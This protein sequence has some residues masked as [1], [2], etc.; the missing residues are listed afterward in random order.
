MVP[1]LHHYNIVSLGVRPR[2]LDRS[3]NRLAARVPEEKAVQAR[4]RH[5]GQQTLHQLDIGLRERNGALHVNDGLRL[6]DNGGSD[7][8]VGVSE[9]GDADT[10]RKVE[11][12]LIVAGQDAQSAAFFK[13]V[14]TQA[15]DTFGDVLV[16][17]GAQVGRGG[18]HGH[19][20]LGRRQGLGDGVQVDGRHFD[21][22]NGDTTKC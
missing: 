15:A 5:H 2:H 20:G 16:G 6:R 11:Q 8:R 13:D 7:S 1:A 10:G 14:V 18:R 3:L 12:L 9:R 19:L 21:V 17:D 22:V 4:V